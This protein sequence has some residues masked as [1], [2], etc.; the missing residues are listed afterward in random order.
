[1]A[2]TM[3]HGGIEGCSFIVTGGSAGIGAACAARLLA[4]G[5]RVTICAR[6]GQRLRAAAERLVANDADASERLHCEVADVT[7]ED[8]VSR[9][10]ERAVADG[11]PL[12]GFVANAGGGGALA[13][14]HRSDVAEYLRVLN[15]NVVSTML[16][17]KHATPALAAAG[18]GAFIAMSS[19]AG[20]VAHPFFGAYPVAKTAV[21][22]LIRNAAD[23]YGAVNVRFNAVAP[24][25]IAT[26]AMAAVP[27]DSAAF[28]S[29]VDNT[30]L[31]DIGGVED[32]AALVRFLLG[33]EARWITGETIRVDGGNHLRRGPDY[34]GFV[35][36]DLQRSDP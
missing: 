10:I 31:G 6:D 23:E 1:M 19:L 17:V 28:R 35:T 33:P 5:A 32:V 34:S 7:C 29:Y 9:L 15:L 18:G 2:H 4:D 30:P 12:H 13:P 20:S 16:C 25:F 8:D 11:G 14:Y 24:G 3:T 27:R 26:E 21:E 22:A 36:L